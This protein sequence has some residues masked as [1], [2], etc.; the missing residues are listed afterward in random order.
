MNLN[1]A[2]NKKGLS[3]VFL[4][5]FLVLIILA[6]CASLFTLISISES[7]SLQLLDQEQIK[8]QEA[9]FLQIGAVSYSDDIIQKVTVNNTGSIPVVISSVYTSIE[10][11]LK[12][13]DTLIKPLCSA[14]ITLSDFNISYSQNLFNDLMITTERGT[15]F[16]AIIKDL[17]ETDAS[18]METIYGPIRLLF[19]EFHWTNFQEKF[20][21]HYLDTADWYEGWKAPPGD[22]AIWRLRIQNIDQR[23]ITLESKSCL[24]LR[25]TQLG[26]APA[27]Y[28][29]DSICSDITIEPREYS[30]LYFVWKSSDPTNRNQNDAKSI[31][32]T[33]DAACISFLIL[34]GHLGELPLGQTIPYEAVFISDD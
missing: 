4:S 33:V 27:T 1:I 15:K 10:L 8:Q 20:S 13:P 5:V 6:L 14:D 34:Q 16:S 24:V 30:T 22:Y 19:E 31:P 3:S 26:Q 9:I 28:Y 12:N 25:N 29:I 18:S 32:N 2:N 23:T 7:S 11:F 17:E 21:N